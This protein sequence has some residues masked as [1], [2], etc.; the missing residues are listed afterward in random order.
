MT[1]I[2]TT[3]TIVTGAEASVKCKRTAVDDL[4]IEASGVLGTVTWSGDALFDGDPIPD[5]EFSSERSI[6]TMTM[7]PSGSRPRMGRKSM[8]SGISR[9]EAP[10]KRPSIQRQESSNP[11]A[12]PLS[13]ASQEITHG[14][15]PMDNPSPPTAHG[16]GQG[17]SRQ[18]GRTRSTSRPASMRAT[19]PIGA[20][21]RMRRSASLARIREPP[22]IS[23]MPRS[24]GSV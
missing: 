10:A 18:S 14:S 11:M 20:Y 8:V 6:R 24:R 5:A 2:G 22:P 4:A 12:S 3:E 15:S 9:W 7:T 21:R 23:S 17:S 19:S 13:G 1:W 16:S